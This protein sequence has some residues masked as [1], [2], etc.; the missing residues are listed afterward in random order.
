MFSSFLCKF[1]AQYAIHA[2]SRLN[3]YCEKFMGQINSMVL[4]ASTIVEP[5]EDRLIFYFQQWN[6]LF[7]FILQK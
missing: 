5:Q 2:A 1:L 6:K 3:L 7:N 4:L